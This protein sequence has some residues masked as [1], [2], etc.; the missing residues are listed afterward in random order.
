MRPSVLGPLCVG[1]RRFHRESK[2]QHDEKNEGGTDLSGYLS[3]LKFSATLRILSIEMWIWI[4]PHRHGRLR[5]THRT[6][7]NAT[8]TTRGRD[9]RES[10]KRMRA[11]WSMCGGLTITTVRCNCKKPANSCGETIFR[12]RQTDKCPRQLLFDK[13]AVGKHG[14]STALRI[15]RTLWRRRVRLA[16]NLEGRVITNSLRGAAAADGMED[17]ACGRFS[18]AAQLC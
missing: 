15:D 13:L 12:A 18:R 17:V 8:G 16:W 10:L 4:E 3:R 5:R 6:L 2:S 9:V 7:I 11:A 1:F 14:R